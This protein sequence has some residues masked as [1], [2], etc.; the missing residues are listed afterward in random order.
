[1]KAEV[2]L[3]FI[4]T[5]QKKYGAE[6]LQLQLLDSDYFAVDQ[7]GSGSFFPLT[8]L[9]VSSIS[10]HYTTESIGCTAMKTSFNFNQR[11]SSIL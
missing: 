2:A 1:V 9:Y 6:A 10:I 7:I 8:K 3:T 5:Q 4:S 11:F